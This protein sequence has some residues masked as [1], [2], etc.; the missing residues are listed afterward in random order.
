[1]RQRLPLLL[2]AAAL[3]CPD[4]LHGQET[5]FGISG[6][7]NFG[8]GAASK[9]AVDIAGIPVTG[10]DGPGQFLSAFVERRHSG[11]LFSMRLEAFYSRLSSGPKSSSA[12]GRAALRDNTIGLALT[13]RH[14]LRGGSGLRPYGLLGAGV[15][16]SMLGT[17]PDPAATNVSES[18]SAMGL[19]MH[20]GAGLEWKLGGQTLF[21]ELRFH[22]ALHQR[23]GGAF[24]PLAVGIKF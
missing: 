21:T 22:Q 20:V 12:L 11:S 16:A 23:R 15:Y 13:L 7:L 2:V 18:R 10:A 8:G 9:V 6:G 24:M 19:G 1:M 14:D 5:S 17:N 3:V 4:L